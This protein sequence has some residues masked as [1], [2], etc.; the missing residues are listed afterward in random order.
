[1]INKIT[2]QRRSLERSLTQSLKNSKGKTKMKTELTE[3]KIRLW[4]RTTSFCKFLL[5]YGTDF[6]ILSVQSLVIKRFK[7][8]SVNF[9]QFSFSEYRK[10]MPR[11]A[12]SWKEPQLK[13]IFENEINA[14]ENEKLPMETKSVQTDEEEK[15]QTVM[16][17]SQS[18][19]TDIGIQCSIIER[20]ILK[21]DKAEETCLSMDI[22]IECSLLTTR[23]L[24]NLYE[25]PRISSIS[26]ISNDTFVVV[27]Q[28]NYVV[29]LCSLAFS[30]NFVKLE[31]CTDSTVTSWCIAIRTGSSEVIIFD[32]DWRYKSCI[33]N[34]SVLFATS[35]L[36]NLLACTTNYAIAVFLPDM[37]LLKR[38]EFTDTKGNSLVIKDP[39]FGCIISS[40]KFAL[41]DLDNDF[42]L[43]FDENAQ[44]FRKEFCFPGPIATDK[45]DL[46]Y[47]ADF[48]EHRI[49][50]TNFEGSL[51]NTINLLPHVS[52][53]RSISISSDNKLAVAF[54][55]SVSLFQL[56]MKNNS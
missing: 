2:A 5:K 38:L 9:D 20:D 11:L 4:E 41:S 37:K 27:D 25:R 43:M 1:M 39:R 18:E 7:H 10:T 47:I 53:P 30:G 13:L 19:N 55:N 21:D 56:G 15:I 48:Y 31:N 6:E 16:G 49:I 23:C 46:I 34:V 50:V 3:N 54:R 52:H 36:S 29:H 44:L 35:P 28:C 45:D 26:W 22:S 33:S 8:T 17:I 40:G 32:H 24:V 12:T 51:R 14:F 42:V